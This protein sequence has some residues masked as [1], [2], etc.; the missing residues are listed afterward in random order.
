MRVISFI[1]DPP[2]IIKILDHLARNAQPRKRGPP[3]QHQLPHEL[4]S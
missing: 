4:A 2:V 1:T 3:S